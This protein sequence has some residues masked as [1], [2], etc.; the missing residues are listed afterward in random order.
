M[1]TLI[2][3]MSAGALHAAF[4]GA[5][6]AQQGFP[7]AY[8]HTPIVMQSVSEKPVLS[9]RW[10][11]SGGMGVEYV[12]AQDIVDYINSLVGPS[13]RVPDFKTGVQFFVAA[14]L[15]V[16]DEWTLKLEYAYLLL[17]FYP[18]GTFGVT[19]FTCAVHMPTLLVQYVLA[20]EGVYNVK[21]GTGMGYH[22]GS[23]TEE[24]P[25]VSGRWTGKGIGT[26]LDLEANTAFSEEFFGYLGVD[27]RW[28][29][30]GDLQPTL[31][32][33]SSSLVETPSLHFFSLGARLGFTYYF[34][35][36]I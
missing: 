26:I 25:Q 16:V 30:I 11:F 6:L 7:E 23:L 13:G 32:G 18:P 9:P 22:F 19:D 33:G 15:P 5:T 24:S 12:N 27:L 17:S 21:V 1:R 8:E 2:T 36:S 35:P 28:D 31:V 29:F 3:L 14:T 34:S 4:A 10:G 20:D